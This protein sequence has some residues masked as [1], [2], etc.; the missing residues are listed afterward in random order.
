VNKLGC[1]SSAKIFFLSYTSIIRTTKSEDILPTGILCQIRRIN[2]I[3][4]GG[5]NS[6]SHLER[7]GE[8]ESGGRRTVSQGI[9]MRVGKDG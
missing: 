6:A 9:S 1:G 5:E 8:S 7:E 4:G 3:R 2:T